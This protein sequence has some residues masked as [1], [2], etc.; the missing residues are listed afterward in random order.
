M[1]SLNKRW[2]ILVNVVIILGILAF[3][4]QYARRES[5]ETAQAQ[6]RAFEDTTA[7]MEQVTVNYLEGEQRICDVWAHYINAKGMTMEEATA[8]VATSHVLPD[9]SAHLLYYDDGSFSGLATRPLTPDGAFPTVSYAILNLFPEPERVTPPGQGVGVTRAYTNPVNGV[10]SLAFCNRVTLLDPDTG[11]ARGALLLRVVPLTEL[12]ERWVFP[13]EEYKAAEISLI[14]AEG[15][16]VIKGPSFGNAS[17]FEFYRANNPAGQ[18]GRDNIQREIVG[19]TGSFV[20]KNARGEDCLIAHTPVQ[21]TSNWNILGYLRTADLNQ[22]TVDW[23]LIGCVTGGLLLLLAADVFFMRY[24]NRRLQEAARAAEAANNAKTE[25][26]STMSHDIRTPMNAIIG[27]TTIAERNPGDRETVS[28]CLRKI[29]L[30]GSHLL[31]LINDILDISKVESG[32][33]RLSPVRFSIAESAENL[34]NISQPMVKEKNIDFNFRVGGIETEYLYA[35]QLRLNQVLINILSNAIKYTEPGGSVNVELWEEKAAG[36]GRVGLVYRVADTGIGMTEDFM[37][38]MYQPFSRQTDSRVNTIQ[39]TGL[40]LAITKQM[41]DL[42]GGSIECQSRPG[43]G[44]TFTVRLE[45]PAA[46]RQPEELLLEPVDV[47]IADDDP[48]LL[49]TARDALR[50]LGARA[51]TA[52]AGPEA[53]QLVAERHAAGR[54]FG[55]VILDWRMPGMD[56][57]EAA[58]AIRDQVGSQVPILLI[59][60]YDWSDIE[61]RAR[62]AGANGFIGKPLFRSKLYDKISEVLGVERDRAVTEDD[63]SD[64]AG[65]RILVAEDNDVNWDVISTLLEMFDIRCERAENG[66]LA[67]EKLRAARPGQYDLVFMDIQMPVMNGL[68]ATKAIR[69]LGKPWPGE[70]PIIAM[71]ADAF[72]ENIAECLAI[73]MDGHIAKPIDIKLVLKELRR[74]RERK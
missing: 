65:M 2:I 21:A 25:F 37:K 32:K 15:G 17:F 35:D 63:N 48:V 13:N 56:G 36:D 23:L 61:D 62:E 29:S 47:L 49:E 12:E 3:V 73:G 55:V 22:T 34:V 18:S 1:R 19:A 40:G 10:Q 6:I 9:T 53:V 39:G 71:T 66:L 57:I 7:D 67:V 31:T 4:F 11:A 26:L 41:V 28:E 5:L 43:A 24:F 74:I 69:A 42:M 70:I 52:A 50:S 68:E 30:A 27:L 14:D 59:S 44:T 38:T 58:R 16:Y 64:I 60:A 54:D 8:F 72:S 51:E 33:L 45:L 46:E 20:M